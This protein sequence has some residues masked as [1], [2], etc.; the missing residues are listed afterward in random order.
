MI[1]FRLA[2]SLEAYTVYTV[3]YWRLVNLAEGNLEKSQ[4]KQRPSR[5]SLKSRPEIF[6]RKKRPSR[7]REMMKKEN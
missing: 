3:Q 1:V 6:Y 4:K 7:S 2:R 5:G